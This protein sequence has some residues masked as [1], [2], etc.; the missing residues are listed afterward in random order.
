M[1][2]ENLSLQ[3]IAAE[4]L[5]PGTAED[6]DGA[7]PVEDTL[8]EGNVDEVADEVTEDQQED[9]DADEAG[10]EADEADADERSADDDQDSDD[11]DDS[12]TDEETADQDDA[13]D[14]VEDGYL[15]VPD[16]ALIEVKI[17]G[18]VVTRSL[19][20]AK[21]ALSGEGAIEQ[22]LKE[23][24]TTRNQLQA[25]HTLLLE[26]F[27]VAQNNLQKVVNQLQNVLFAPSVS[28]PDAA[29]RQTDPAKYLA[30]QDAFE[31]DK[32][33]VAEGQAAVNKLLEDQNSAFADDVQKYRE[34]QAAHLLEALPSL[35]DKEQAP[36]ILGRMAKLAMEKYGYSQQ[37][38]AQA[39]DHRMY[40]MMHDLA[41]FHAARKTSRRKGKGVKNTTDQANKRPLKLRSGNTAAKTRARAKDA[42]RNKLR[43]TAQRTGKVQDVAATLTRG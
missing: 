37:E 33:R 42:E 25:D 17:D 21:K 24:T 26:Q 40:L 7:A 9:A 18:K 31:A 5:K 16:D 43:D 22:R 6:V 35:G 8:D 3:D 29:L 32:K 27:S 30:Q 36:V 14:L 41:E 4:L 11:A 20:E 2:N 15:T 23:V 19:A 38:I 39:S 13:N 1:A 34:A 10:D 28:E 12:E